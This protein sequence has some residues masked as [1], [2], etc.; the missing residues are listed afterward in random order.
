MNMIDHSRMATPP[1]P[2]PPYLRRL[3][4]VS[5]ALCVASALG[6]IGIEPIR[7]LSIYA[8]ALV[9]LAMLGAIVTVA[10]YWVLRRRV[11]AAY[12]T[13]AREAAHIDG[14]VRGID[15]RRRQGR[16]G[17]VLDRRTAEPV[18]VFTQLWRSAVSLGRRA[19]GWMPR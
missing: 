8:V 5:A 7:Q 6:V 15:L 13:P 19:A 9:A 18:G 11:E 10:L 16:G 12:W 14:V 2:Q 4:I 3:R 17:I 1:A